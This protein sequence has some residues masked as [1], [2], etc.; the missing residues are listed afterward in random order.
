MK[1]HVLVLGDSLAGLVTA[2]R[3]SLADF[4]VT[5][6]KTNEHP[7]QLTGSPS[8]SDQSQSSDS[9]FSENA[10]ALLEEPSGPHIFLGP[11]PHTETLWNE[12][13][14]AIPSLPWNPVSLE[15]QTSSSALSH[16]RQPWLPAPWHS[17][18]GI[19]TFSALPYGQRWTLLNFLEKVWEGQEELP[20]SLDLQTSDSWL[21]NRGQTNDIQKIL[22]NPLCRF[23]LGTTLSQT[24]AGTFTSILTRIFFCT[25]NHR[26]RVAQMPQLSRLFQHTIIQRLEQQG[27]SIEHTPSIEHL[28]VGMDQVTGVCLSDG[29]LYSADW[30]VAAVHPTKLSSFLPERLLARYSSFHQIHRITVAPMVK[31][32][33]L[34]DHK[35]NK[36][37]LILRDGQFSW[38]LCSPTQATKGPCTLISCVSTGDTNFLAESDEHI[39]ACA[40]ETLHRILPS[41]AVEGSLHHHRYSIVRQPFGFVPQIQGAE[42]PRPTNQSPIK[43][44]LLAGSWTETGAY[45][46]IESAIASGDQCAQAVNNQRQKHH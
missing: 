38:L 22:W 40:L 10:K 28:Q 18:W 26:P 16:F 2:W 3:L 46:E 41:Q 23:L 42:S 7:Q 6:L 37:R 11:C 45:T 30:Y 20:S 5:L 31:F 1:P 29:T 27:V 25:R 14:E 19:A 12:L 8:L 9:S 21:T 33:V 39:H 34:S 36:S 44:F 17:M 32:K 4:R 43:N 13:G 24:R 35:I 15:C